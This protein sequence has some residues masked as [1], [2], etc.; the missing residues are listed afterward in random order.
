MGMGTDARL[1]VSRYESL[2]PGDAEWARRAV[3]PYAAMSPAE[4]L[5]ALA[6]LNG[7]VDALLSGRA[8]EREDGERPF[9]MHWKDPSLGRTR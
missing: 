7:W 3:E 1:D 2:A 9:W 8:P 6:A 4:R 5:R